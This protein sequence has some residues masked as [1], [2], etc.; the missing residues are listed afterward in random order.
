MAVP[1]AAEYAA[2]LAAHRRAEDALTRRHHLIAN[3]RLV[4][5]AA[6]LVVAALAF[7]EPPPHSRLDRGSRDSPSSRWPP[8]MRRCW[9]RRR[10]SGARP[11]YVETGIA[12]LEHRWQGRGATGLAYLPADHPYAEDLDI[13]GAGSLFDLLS[14]PRTASGE[15]TLAAWLLA[16]AVPE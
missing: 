5:T 15:A 1:L 11:R 9:P 3:L 14:T 8:G 10:A 2:R 4:A 13:L 7:A 12:R 6:A 16:P